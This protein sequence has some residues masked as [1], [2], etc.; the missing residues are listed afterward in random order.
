MKRNR[1]NSSS[2][3][4]IAASVAVPEKMVVVKAAYDALCEAAETR[5]LKLEETVTY[6]TLMGEVFF[7]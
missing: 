3:F 5:R 6:H 1:N 4:Q 7:P 2:P